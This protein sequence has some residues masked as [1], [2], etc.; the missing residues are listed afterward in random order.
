MFIQLHLAC[1]FPSAKYQLWSC[2]KSAIADMI[3]ITL[4]RRLEIADQRF[5][6]LKK[7]DV[8]AP[9]FLGSLVFWTPFGLA[10]IVAFFFLSFFL[11]FF[12]FFF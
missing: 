6:F 12:F 4:N 5:A 10:D 3:I 11:S 9:A 2:D 8:N 1:S 7:I